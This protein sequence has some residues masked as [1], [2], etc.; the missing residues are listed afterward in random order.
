[1]TLFAIGRIGLALRS[2]ARSKS[3]GQGA[4]VE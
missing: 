3:K 1:M 4:V 2:Q